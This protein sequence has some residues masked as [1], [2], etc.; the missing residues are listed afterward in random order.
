MAANFSAAL[1]GQRL[2]CLVGFQPFGVGETGA[3]QV[4][5]A[6]IQQVVQRKGMGGADE[7]GPVGVDADMVH[8]RHDQQRRIAQRPLV[9]LQLREGGGQILALALVFPSEAVFTPDV[10]PALAPGGFGRALFEGEEFTLGVFGDRVLKAQQRA[11]VVEMGLGGRAF[12]QFDRAPF[13]DKFLWRHF[14]PQH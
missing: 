1:L 7:A 13:T 10:G 14:L 11:E 9:L 3:Q 2:A 8:V 12:L 4:A 6:R 5:L